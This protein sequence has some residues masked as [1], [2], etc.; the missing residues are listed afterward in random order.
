MAY[1]TYWWWNWGLFMTLFYQHSCY[2]LCGYFGYLYDILAR[3]LD[4]YIMLYQLYP[5]ISLYPTLSHYIP[6]LS[7]FGWQKMPAITSKKKNTGLARR[8]ALGDPSGKA[9]GP[10]WR[11]PSVFT[12]WEQRETSFAVKNPYWC[13]VQCEA[14]K[15][16]KLV[17]NSNNYGLW[18]L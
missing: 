4:T 12:S 1:T 6:A 8:G 5:V 18:Y 3:W 15:I 2:L 9:I 7:H 17:Y 14:P 16:A 10:R 13:L 11:W